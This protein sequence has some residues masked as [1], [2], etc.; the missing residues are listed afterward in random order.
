MNIKFLKAGS[1]DSILI[2]HNSKNII[3]DGGNDS[4]SLI[5]EVDKIIESNQ[6][7]D[8]II[9]T[10]HDDDHIKGIIELV[11][12]IEKY[13][14]I[15]CSDF[16][17]EMLFN[18][19]NK[20]L[21]KKDKNNYLSYQQAFDLEE[22]LLE[23][24]INWNG[25]N[26]ESE[27]IEFDGLEIDFL[28]PTKLDLESYAMSSGAYLTSDFKSDWESSLY[29]LDK[30]INDD[31]LDISNPNRSSIVII[32]KYNGKKILLPGDV[33]PSRLDA[34]LQ[35]LI[36]TEPSCYFDLIKLPH[37]GSY[38]SLSETIL[39]KINCNNF[40]ISANGKKQNLPNKRAFL[41][42]FKY[43]DRTNKKTI[44]FLFN[45]NEVIDSL[46]ITDKEKRDY[47]FTLK[48]STENYGISY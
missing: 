28:S 44:N 10:H 35:K 14:R 19:P 47:N 42:I 22:L 16:F 7:I 23:N 48:P 11:K 31:S 32:L 6:V 24:N 34:I 37:H 21:Q 40:V 43:M 8:L 46:N 26:E 27:S 2:Q 41:K 38:R 12:Y 18:S 29:K 5:S 9:V 33:T 1:G 30:H 4:K 15:K 17:K 25:C 13:P 3:I 39:K 20:I 36:G 45:Y